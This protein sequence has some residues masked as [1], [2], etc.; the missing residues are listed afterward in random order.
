MIQSL[1]LRGQTV[2]TMS[3]SENAA[4]L[5]ADIDSGRT[6]DKVPGADPAAAPLGTDEEAGGTPTAPEA[7][8]QA[9]QQET[10][11]PHETRPRRGPGHAWIQI[12]IVALLAGVF[13]AWGLLGRP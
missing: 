9:R 2:A 13:I 6:G 11:R 4:R 5:R 1:S 3:S 10:A 8:A 7:I 12:A